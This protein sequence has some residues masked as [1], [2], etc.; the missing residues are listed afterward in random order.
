MTITGKDKQ[1]LAGELALGVLEGQERVDAMRL[2]LSD[3]DFAAKVETW[4][5]D[6]G[7]LYDDLPE[8]EPSAAVWERISAD[9]GGVAND[10][11]STRSLAFWRG[12]ALMSGAVAAALMVALVLPRDE[13]VVPEQPQ[14]YAI[15]QLSSDIEGLKLAARFDPAAAQL[16]VRVDGMPQTDTVPVLWVVSADATV[17]PLGIINRNGETVMTVESAPRALIRDGAAFSVSM[18]PETEK[19]Y[20][21]PS[22]DFVAQGTIT[23]I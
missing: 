14:S 17:Q 8:A 16:R 12:G 7:G 4:R 1:V 21:Q 11:G 9:I 2:M 6:L 23:T 15:A 5:E 19:P 13:D 3:P 18:E 22:A 20:A 10:S